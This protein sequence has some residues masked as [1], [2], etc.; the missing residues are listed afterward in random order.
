MSLVGIFGQAMSDLN[1]IKL[2]VGDLRDQV[3]CPVQPHFEK[4]FHSLQ[5]QISSLFRAIP[6]HKGGVSRSSRTLGGDAVDAA[7]SS[8][9]SDCRASFGS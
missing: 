9:E 5:T 4:Y 7:A 3:I 6:A 8:R 1:H 2:D